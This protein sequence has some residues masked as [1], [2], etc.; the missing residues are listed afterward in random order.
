VGSS[1]KPNHKEAFID[2]LEKGYALTMDLNKCWNEWRT[3]LTENLS[4]AWLGEVSAE[5]A[6]LKAHKDVQKILDKA[7]SK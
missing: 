4:L 6:M 5:Q 3:A 1:S 7:Y 2:P